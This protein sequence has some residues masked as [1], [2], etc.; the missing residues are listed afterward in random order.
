MAEGREIID[1]ERGYWLQVDY[2][3]ASL[4]LGW[5][6]ATYVEGGKKLKPR[7]MVIGERSATDPNEL[8]FR[9]ASDTD[10]LVHKTRIYK[11]ESADFYTFCVTDPAEERSNDE[12]LGTFA[13]YPATN[14]ARYVTCLLDYGQGVYLTDDL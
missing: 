13:W 14:E 7:K 2:G 9:S 5:V 3:K 11:S 4:A 12:L 6:Y 8:S 1:G 10:S